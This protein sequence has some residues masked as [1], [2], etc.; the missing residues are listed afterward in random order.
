[1]VWEEFKEWR[2]GWREKE[3]EEGQPSRAEEEERGG[4][5]N[6]GRRASGEGGYE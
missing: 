4:R 2:G 5:E 3:V 1:M 6:E